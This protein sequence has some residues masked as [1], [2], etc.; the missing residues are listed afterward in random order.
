MGLVGPDRKPSRRRFNVYRNNVGSSLVEALGDNF[1]VIKML[2][3]DAFFDAMARVYY[4]GNFPKVP[5]LFRYGAEF[6]TFL[7]T[8]E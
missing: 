3:G 1:P 2:V 5:M 8:F 6:P 7:E 4:T